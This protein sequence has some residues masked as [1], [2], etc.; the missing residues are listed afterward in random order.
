M[1][2]RIAII[3]FIMFIIICGMGASARTVSQVKLDSALTEA[4]ER[5]V[6]PYGHDASGDGKLMLMMSTLSHERDDYKYLSHFIPEEFLDKKNS[7]P[8]FVFMLSHTGHLRKP[9]VEIFD[10]TTYAIIGDTYVFIKEVPPS[11][12]TPTGRRCYNI[13]HYDNYCN[14]DP[15]WISITKV[16]GRYRLLSSAS[17]L[18]YCE[19]A[20]SANTQ[21]YKDFVELPAVMVSEDFY[22]RMPRYRDK[23]ICTLL[24]EWPGDSVAAVCLPQRFVTAERLADC[25]A[26]ITRDAARR[27]LYMTRTL[28]EGLNL[29]PTT[30]YN[31]PVNTAPPA[32][33]R[34]MYYPAIYRPLTVLTAQE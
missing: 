19:S 29:I 18:R 32:Y 25:V 1:Y 28:S 34:D 27:P 14:Y 24:A 2:K 21:A 26:V 7:E 4:I 16:D 10:P 11:Y 5:L 6:I 20:I 23:G 13:V 31:A 9:T 17:A 8:I 3:N 30:I 15:H 33:S 12:T 22:D